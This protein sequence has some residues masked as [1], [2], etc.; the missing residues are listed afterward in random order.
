MKIRAA[1]ALVVTLAV[2]GSAS[3]TPGPAAVARAWSAAVN[4]G[5]NVAAAN[6]F[7]KNAVVAQ[8]GYVLHLTTHKLA[9]QWNEGLPCSGRILKITVRKDVA[10]ATFLLSQRP[11]KRCDGPGQ[12]ARAAFKVRKGKI[13]L[14]VQLPLVETKKSTTTTTTGPIAA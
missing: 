4:R 14:W 1:G 7:A 6:L 9:V 5:D 2:V 8:G 12:K 3:A 10:D 13:V 11:H